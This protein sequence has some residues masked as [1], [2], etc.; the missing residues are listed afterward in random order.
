MS[1]GLVAMSS[2][3]N[4]VPLRVE[5]QRSALTSHLVRDVHLP[6]G[7][8]AGPQAVVAHHRRGADLPVA[9]LLFR[10]HLPNVPLLADGEDLLGRI[11]DEAP[12]LGLLVVELARLR[13]ASLGGLPV[14]DL[15]TTSVRHRSSA[16]RGQQARGVIEVACEPIPCQAMVCTVPREGNHLSLLVIA[17]VQF[18]GELAA[19]RSRPFRHGGPGSLHAR[20]RHLSHQ[21]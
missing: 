17:T 11:I 21:T 6:G 2:A 12:A 13:E 16:L 18:V 14:A 5:V 9:I 15:G 3:L 19:D 10:L 20:Q 7:L 8:I 1:V 4:A